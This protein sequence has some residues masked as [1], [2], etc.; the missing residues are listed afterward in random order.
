MVAST[1]EVAKGLKFKTRSRNYLIYLIVLMGMVALLDQYLSMIKM[2]TIP[3]IIEEYGV[4]AGTF[5][6]SEGI[7]LSATFGIFLL[8]GLN[9]M[10]GRRY[11]SLVL[12]VLMG[13]SGL[14][15][16]FLTPTFQT[17]MLFYTLAMFTGVSNMWSIPVSE[18]SPAEKRAKYVTI[19]YVIGLI[20]IQA[21]MPSLLM[22]VMGL[23]W[24][25]L[26]GVSFIIMLPMLAMWTGMKETQRYNLIKRE[27]R[28]GKR[29]KH[30]FGIG[31]ITK[32]DIRYILIAASIWMTWLVYSFLK[33]WAGYYLMEIHGYTRQQ[34]DTTLLFVLLC[35]IAG[36]ILG[37]KLL[38]KIGRMR[39][40]IIG[41]IGQVAILI[42]MAFARGWLL[43]V[44]AA[45]VGFFT[46]FTYTWIAVYIPE[47][48]PT[49][50]RGACMGWTTT[51]ARISYV[52]GPLLAGVLLDRFP[53]M[54]GF[55]LVAAGII[56]VPMLIVLVIRPYET[57]NLELED[58]E[59][60]R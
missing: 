4:D 24:K 8:N 40:F 34:W 26:Y 25:W 53:D 47:I 20:P 19:T 58:I 10:I 18:E 39:A 5:S 1:N 56:V 16:V 59:T 60:A 44:A 2:T 36:G 38:D 43:P 42:M 14:G 41:Y 21:L 13:I 12:M 3:F 57:S 27:R 55:W 35:A 28:E 32:N 30:L 17:F 9:D 50:R 49:E 6:R 45:G 52:V 46:S 48:F 7:W 54:V 23:S 31:V 15:I 11:A 37:G 22:D 51:V 29:K 33:D